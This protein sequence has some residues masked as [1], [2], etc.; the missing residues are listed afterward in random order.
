MGAFLHRAGTGEQ[1]DLVGLIGKRDRGFLT[2]QNVPVALFH[3][4]HAQIGGIGSA[5][6]FGQPEGD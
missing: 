4:G 5:A 6:G 3:R 1:D 2:V